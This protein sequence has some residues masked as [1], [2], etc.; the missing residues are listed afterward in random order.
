MRH[1][2]SHPCA[3]AAV[4][5]AS[6]MATMASVLTALPG[7]DSGINPRCRQPPANTFDASMRKPPHY[8]TYSIA[9]GDQEP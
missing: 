8:G 7:G 6:S 2:D 9:Y 3:T 5:R 4:F 1:S